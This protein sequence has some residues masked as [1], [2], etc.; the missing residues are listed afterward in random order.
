MVARVGTGTTVGAVITAM[1]G[2]A[3]TAEGATAA[4]GAVISEVGA[5]GVSMVVAGVIGRD[6]AVVGIIEP[7]GLNRESKGCLK[8]VQRKRFAHSKGGTM[9]PSKSIAFLSIAFS[10][11]SRHP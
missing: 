8:F 2:M 6:M 7:C 5:A 3:F 4:V 10:R 9:K 1:A 11:W